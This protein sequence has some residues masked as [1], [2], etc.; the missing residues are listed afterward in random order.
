MTKTRGETFAVLASF[1]HLAVTAC[2]TY[3]VSKAVPAFERLFR[4]R[5][6]DEPQLALQQYLVGLATLARQRIAARAELRTPRQSHLRWRIGCRL[7]GFLQALGQ[8]HSYRRIQLRA[9]AS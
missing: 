7:A 2:P 3:Q 1:W 5:H 9:L 4:L 6:P 8:R